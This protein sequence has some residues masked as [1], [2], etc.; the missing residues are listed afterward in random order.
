[1]PAEAMSRDPE[2][3]ADWL[4]GRHTPFKNN[5]DKIE[6]FLEEQGIVKHC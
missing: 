2:Q 1:V 3:L 6:W 5:R 4:S